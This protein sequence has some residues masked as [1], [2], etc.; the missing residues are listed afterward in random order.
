[1]RR[2]YFILFRLQFSILILNFKTRIISSVDIPMLTFSGYLLKKM[3][4]FFTIHWF[5]EKVEETKETKKQNNLHVKQPKLFLYNV[6]LLRKWN[7]Y[8][9]YFHS[10]PS[11]SVDFDVHFFTTKKNANHSLFFSFF[12]RS[13]K[14]GDAFFFSVL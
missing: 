6:F 1:M 12:Y 8:F 4:S 9:V 10:E 3:H 2:I 11:K 5:I 13:K 14:F 7:H